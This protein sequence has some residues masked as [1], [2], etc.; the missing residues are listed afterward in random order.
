VWAKPNSLKGNVVDRNIDIDIDIRDILALVNI[1]VITAATV[2][3]G[4]GVLVL[5]S[6]ITDGVVFRVIL[7]AISIGIG[8][9]IGFASHAIVDNLAAGYLASARLRALKWADEDKRDLE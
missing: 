3:V 5:L 8:I 1:V 9:A 6:V 7:C 2:I 4:A